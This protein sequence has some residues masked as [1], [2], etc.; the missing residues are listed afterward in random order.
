MNQNLI[1]VGRV[2]SRRVQTPW[3]FHCPMCPVMHGFHF[4]PTQEA[5]WG[6]AERHLFK[7]HPNIR[8]RAEW[9][10][11]MAMRGKLK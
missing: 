10:Q 11:E 2:K 8:T 9:M 4:K 5:A 7:H 1:N 3:W 6:E